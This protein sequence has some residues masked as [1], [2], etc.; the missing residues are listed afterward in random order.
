MWQPPDATMSSDVNCVPRWSPGDDTS[1][2]N[3]TATR[4]AW[5]SL[6]PHTLL[7]HSQCACRDT[8]EPH[9]IIVSLATQLDWGPWP[10]S[11]WHILTPWSVSLSLFFFHNKLW[12]INMFLFLLFVF[13]F[14]CFLRKRTPSSSMP[15]TISASARGA[16]AFF[17]ARPWNRRHRRDHSVSP[18]PHCRVKFFHVLHP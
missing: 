6:A 14:V 2:G 11:L 12:I 1:P 16:S 5:L 18:L 8:P 9:L 13:C 17:N 7:I 15:S 3:P 10:T 4:S